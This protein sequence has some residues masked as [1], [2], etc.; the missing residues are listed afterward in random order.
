MSR[1]ASPLSRTTAVVALL[2]AVFADAASAAPVYR[3]QDAAGGLH[4]SNRSEVVPDFAH[5]MELPP[6]RAPLTVPR[7]A[8]P[9]GV[10]GKQAQ[11]RARLVSSE[12]CGPG[13]SSGVG[14]AIVSRL[15]GARQSENL[16]VFVGGVPVLYRPGA[17]VTVWGE[18]VSDDR[19][20]PIEQASIAYPEGGVCPER[21]PLHR[22][23]VS[24]A[25]RVTSRGLCDDYRRAFA[26]VGVA[27][28]RD[29][30][31]ARSFGVLA[32][33]F[34]EIAAQGYTARERGQGVL[35]RD[36]SLADR[37]FSAGGGW[38]VMPALEARARDVRLP[39]WVVEAH[40]AQTEEL[41]EETAGFVEELTVALE[42]IDRSA[43]ARGCW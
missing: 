9:G 7:A 4:F 41:A 39:P 28:S 19:S 21:P 3:W 17:V 22:Y 42:E 29:Q 38:T 37:T 27:V 43:R 24:S 11:S 13:D 20:A 15:V 35:V 34:S 14:R 26:E 5:E 23:A 2:T 25:S 33:D 40:I 16:T 32:D 10:T 18:D 1:L 36:A 8:A 30:R 12:E 6:V 31:I